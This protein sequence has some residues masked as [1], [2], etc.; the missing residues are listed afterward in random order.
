MNVITKRVLMLVG[1]SI[2]EEIIT[3][4]VNDKT[5]SSFRDD[6]VQFFRKT[7]DKTTNEVDD[8]LVEMAIKTIMAPGKYIAHTK[9]LCAILR[10]YIQSNQ[11]EWDDIVFLPILDQIEKLGITAAVK[12]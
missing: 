3:S 4:I 6:L 12:E 7:A 5:I 11:V 10:K 8:A 1:P 2:L 9:E